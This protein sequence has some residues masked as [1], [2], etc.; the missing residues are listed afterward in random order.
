MTPA[1]FLE[2]TNLS[3]LKCLC[4]VHFYF[5]T[6]FFFL[7]NIIECQT[8]LLN[9]VLSQD[10][11]TL[12]LVRSPSRDCLFSDA[13]LSHSLVHAAAIQHLMAGRPL[14]SSGLS[15]RNTRKASTAAL[16]HADEGEN[17]NLRK[18]LFFFLPV[19]CENQETSIW[20]FPRLFSLWFYP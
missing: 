20:V 8:F 16:R 15:R 6:F 9:S 17:L 3:P 10:A 13:K 11:L 19:V 12:S 5:S 18:I 1:P 14:S 2:K 7:K 4:P